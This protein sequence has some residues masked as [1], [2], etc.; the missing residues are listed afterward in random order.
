[1]Q[2]RVALAVAVAATTSFGVGVV[3]FGAVGS[4][5]LFGFNGPSGPVGPRS[6]MIVKH[7]IET[8]DQVVVVAPLVPSAAA[9]RRPSNLAALVDA[10]GHA[11]AASGPVSSVPI[12]TSASTT[13]AP[14]VLVAPNLVVQDASTTGPAVGTTSSSTQS[15]GA[16]VQPKFRSSTSPAGAQA[17][18]NPSPTDAP[19][20][21]ST[22]AAPLVAA[23][24]AAPPNT[25]SPVANATALTTATPDITVSPETSAAPVAT[26]G[27]DTTEAPGTTQLP[28]TPTPPA[29]TAST[30]ATTSATT[31]SGLPQSGTTTTVRPRGVPA[32]WPANKPIPPMP[33]GCQEPQLEDNGIWNCDH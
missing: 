33:P 18:P 21:P 32:D 9:A 5:H 30:S 17:A 11:L 4:A 10:G 23:T 1:M 6:E 7:R 29:T 8:I 28:V 22:T 15:T 12:V 31:T 2:R 26:E 14:S 13:S 3:A 24:T 16:A 19:I 27:R 25:A 20:T